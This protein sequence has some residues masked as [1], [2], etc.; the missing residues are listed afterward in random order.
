MLFRSHTLGLSGQSYL[1]GVFAW[2]GFLYYKWVFTDLSGPLNAVINDILTIQARGPK[3]VESQTYIPSARERIKT[4][5][6]QA[7]AGVSAL[8]QVY[9][10]AFEGLT[11]QSD[12]LRFRDFLLKAPSMFIQ[13]GEQLG[14]VQ[15]VV[16]FWTYR[17]P[18][19]RPRF[20]GFD[21]LADLFLDFEDSL[22]GIGVASDSAAHDFLGGDK[23][24]LAH[25]G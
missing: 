4:K 18:Q 5:L 9:N 19:G 24:W 14:A 12:P 6:I 1:D 22:S 17:M 23:P 20:I 7:H 2:R 13:L 16:S 11:A 25:A 3:S 15:H 8:L 21:E 10:H